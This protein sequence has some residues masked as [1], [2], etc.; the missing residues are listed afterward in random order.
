MVLNN[1]FTTTKVA[2]N[3]FIKIN[4]TLMLHEAF[5]EAN[6]RGPLMEPV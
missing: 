3:C 4:V 2:L 5:V 6:K 1:N